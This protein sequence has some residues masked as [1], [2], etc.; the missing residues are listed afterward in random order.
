MGP[1][2]RVRLFAGARE[3][4]GAPSL[5]WP[6]PTAGL[7]IETLLGELVGRYPRLGPIVRHSRFLVNS[8]YVDPKRS[9]VDHG[10]EL[11]IHPPYSGG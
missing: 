3:A 4:V 5:P 6:V 2:I 7:A 11:A 9:R 8:E 1:A 10:D